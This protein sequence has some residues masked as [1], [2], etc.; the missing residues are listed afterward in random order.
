MDS[1]T[2]QRIILDK[3]GKKLTLISK[4]RNEPANFF[5]H[6]M[7]RRGSENLITTARVLGKDLK[8]DQEKRFLTVSESRK[9]NGGSYHKG[10]GQRA[11]E[12]HSLQ[13]LSARNSMTMMILGPLH[14][15]A[16]EKLVQVF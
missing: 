15:T 14:F 8:D 5:V 9:A 16:K 6:A 11:V 10:A 4:I 2:N 12:E 7:R 1:K 13:R 3:L